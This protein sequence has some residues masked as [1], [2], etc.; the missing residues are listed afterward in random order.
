MRLPANEIE[1]V[2]RQLAQRPAGVAEAEWQAQVFTE[3][4]LWYD[5]VA[6]WSALID[7]F[8][9]RA[10]LHEKRGQVYDQLPVTQS[11]ADEDYAAAA[12]LR[13]GAR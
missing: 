11:L 10:D 8:P 7:R 13:A 2:S 12:R 3:R 4:R 6:A 1:A 5:A 9:D